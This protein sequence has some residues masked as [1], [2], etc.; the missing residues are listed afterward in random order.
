MRKTQIK[1]EGE[2]RVL[3]AS[4]FERGFAAISVDGDIAEQ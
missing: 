3:C 1:T 2:D 4:S